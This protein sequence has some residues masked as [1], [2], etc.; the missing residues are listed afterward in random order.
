VKRKLKDILDMDDPSERTILGN[1]MLRDYL[2]GLT[3]AFFTPIISD[4]ASTLQVSNMRE[5]AAERALIAADKEEAVSGSSSKD[6]TNDAPAFEVKGFVDGIA[7]TKKW[8][9]GL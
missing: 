8:A 3:T 5:S 4:S 9:L 6:V 2:A 7:K 1:K